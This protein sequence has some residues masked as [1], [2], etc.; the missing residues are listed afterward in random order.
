MNV[1]QIMTRNV[2][3]CR[4]SDT[5]A[6]AAR[7]MWDGDIGCLPVID[8]EGH[9]AGII[10]DRDIC[11]AACMRGQPLSGMHVRQAMSAGVHACMPSDDLGVVEANMAKY[12]VRR[13][14][15]I[16]DEGD[17]AGIISLNDLARAAAHRGGKSNGVPSA[18]QVATTLAAIAEPRLRS[19]AAPSETSAAPS[20]A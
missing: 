6:V 5:M 16:N 10:T 4:P 11:M 8:R 1:A 3:T 18:K 20:P 12:K 14:P 15:V 17:L 19:P 13:M 9:V 7:L 2:A